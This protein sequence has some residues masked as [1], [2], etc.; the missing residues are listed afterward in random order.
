MGRW[1][2]RTGYRDADSLY[3]KKGKRAWTKIGAAT[4][5][6]SSLLGT[7]AAANYAKR[8]GLSKKDAAKA[9]AVSTLG[10]AAAGAL[11]GGLGTRVDNL[12]RKYIYGPVNKAIIGG[13]EK[14]HVG[15]SSEMSDA[16][17]RARRRR[18]ARNIAI[19]AGGAAAAGLAGYG[20][21]RAAKR[22]G[23]SVPLGNADRVK[24]ALST[25]PVTNKSF[26]PKSAAVVNG[27]K[28]TVRERRMFT[29]AAVKN[30]RITR[31]MHNYNGLSPAQKKKVFRAN[32]Q[33]RGKRQRLRRR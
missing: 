8:Y 3:T 32:Q 14:G 24:S 5:G 10:G 2:Q 4:V 1:E 31:S 9:I 28:L 20:I 6:A 30:P 26:H 13:D 7:A 19:G 33:L 18:I 12:R 11:A 22:G 27:R 25:R 21:Y 17:R 29:R 23:A 16:E 15:S